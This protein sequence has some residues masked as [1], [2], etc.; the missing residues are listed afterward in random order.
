MKHASIKTSPVF[1]DVC[2]YI[3]S[4]VGGSSALSV[5]R[6]SHCPPLDLHL[7][8]YK[9]EKKVLVLPEQVSSF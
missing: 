3:E 8:T 5:L 1:A 6:V 9:G 7:S 2:N 4:P